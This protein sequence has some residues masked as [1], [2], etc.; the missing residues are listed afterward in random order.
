[1]PS[2]ICA[3]RRFRSARAFTQSDPDLLC[4]LLTD[5]DTSYGQRRLIMRRSSLGAHARRYV[6][7]FDT[8][9]S[10][11]NSSHF[12]G[13]TFKAVSGIT[14]HIFF[15]TRIKLQ[16]LNMARVLDCTKINQNIRAFPHVRFGVI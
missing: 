12:R 13:C 11:S 7:P 4:A 2:D 3:Q 16:S 1:M 8:Q 5:R 9:L 14:M 15:N 10:I 6:S